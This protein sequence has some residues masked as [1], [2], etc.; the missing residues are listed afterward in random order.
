MREN[1]ESRESEAEEESGFKKEIQELFE[2]EKKGELATS[3]FYREGDKEEFDVNKLTD[4]DEIMWRRIKEFS[5][6]EEEVDEVVKEFDKYKEKLSL[7]AESS[8]EKLAS[9][10]SSVLTAKVYGR[11]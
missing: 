7:G 6:A 1:F 8:S 9:Y 10:L 3:H 2:Q 11:E 4:E 5:M